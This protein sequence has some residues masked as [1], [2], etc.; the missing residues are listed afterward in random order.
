[1]PDATPAAAP[2][3]APPRKAW[4]RVRRALALVG[5]G[6]FAW[7]AW[8]GTW[9]QPERTDATGLTKGQVESRLFARDGEKW[10]EISAIVDAPIGQVWKVVHDHERMTEFMPRMAKLKVLEDSGTHRRVRIDFKFLVERFTQIDVDV[11]VRP[12]VRL[13]RWKR[14]DGSL[15]VNQGEWIL[16]PLGAGRTFARYEVHVESGLPVPRFLERAILREALKVV[17][18]RVDERIDRLRREDPH[19]LDDAK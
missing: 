16:T 2:V 3:V 9:T 1:M 19:Y 15:P 18:T 6:A 12:E 14:F 8:L 10:V 13:E 4:R 17:L 5:L 11:D 7:A